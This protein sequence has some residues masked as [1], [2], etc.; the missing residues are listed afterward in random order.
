MYELLKEGRIMASLSHTN[1]CVF[2]GICAD[3]QDR[4]GRQLI[5]SELMDCSLFDLLHSPHKLAWTGELTIPLVLSISEGIC[6]GIMYLHGR[7]LVHADLKSSNVLIDYGSSSRPIPK[8]CDFGHVAMRSHP[9]PHH[10]C[11]TPHWAAPEAL[12]QEAVSPASDVFSVGII[13][14]EMLAV[15]QPHRQLTS[16]GQ[17]C[18]AVGWAGEI[19]DMDLLPPLPEEIGH[20]LRSLLLSC[21]AFSAER[22]PLLD[23]VRASLQS[24][25]RQNR[26]ET[27]QLLQ[28]FVEGS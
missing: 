5:I 21:L 13:L 12:R 4:K 27:L 8:I 3:L 9:A 22:R 20:N 7:Q 2:L 6:A 18:G 11:G 24:L 28:S 19:P 26:K 14:W 1:V 16:F 15:D 23:S 25:R 10:R 17:V